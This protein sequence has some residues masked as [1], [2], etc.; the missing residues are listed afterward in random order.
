MPRSPNPTIEE[1]EDEHMR[2]RGNVP[3]R[4]PH[5]ILELSD[6]DGPRNKNSASTS[7]TTKPKSQHNQHLDDEDDDDDLPP[8]PP[9]K[10]SLRKTAL[11]AK[12]TVIN[13][14]ISDLDQVSKKK[15][16]IAHEDSDIEEI[17]NPTESPE[18]ELGE[19]FIM[20]W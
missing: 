20:V 16:K 9:K 18:E 12:P 11:K 7:T 13:S 10:K 1:I 5:H 17:E 6:E 4:N 15:K 3:P 14:D 8:P 19:L 2:P